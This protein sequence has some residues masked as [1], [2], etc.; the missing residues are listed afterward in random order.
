MAVYAIG[1]VQGCVLPLEELLEKLNF[2]SARDKLWLTGDL[3]NRGPDSLNTIRLVRKLDQSVISVLGNHDL[4]FL[5]VAEGIR[6]TR[7]GDTFEQLQ[8]ASDLEEIVYWMRH[9]P[10]VHCDKALKTIMTHAGVYPGWNRKQ[11]I[12]N[13]Q[14]VEKELRGDNYRKFL[15]QMYGKDPVRWKKTLDGWDRL[16]F[17]TNAITRMRYCDFRRNLDFVEKGRPGSQPDDLIPWYQHPEMRCKKWRLVFGHW[18]AL[19]YFQQQNIVSLDSGCVWGGK[20]T[21]VRLDAEYIAPYW[22]LDC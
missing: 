10:M 12:S 13:A 18:S 20:L 17:I 5:A 11:L 7:A 6:C 21:A 16:R 2:D 8:N 22:E 15:K 9:L 14:L 19:G 3:V 4:H 1:D